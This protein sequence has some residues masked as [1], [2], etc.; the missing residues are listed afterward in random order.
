[1]MKKLLLFIF[2]ASISLSFIPTNDN[3]ISIKVYKKDRKLYLLKGSK[4]IAVYDIVLGFN[5]EGDKMQE[6]DGKTPEGTF[7][8]RAKYPHK[9]WNK[10]IWFDYPNKESIRKFNERT[11]NK[12]LDAKATIGGDVGIHGVPKGMD[13]AIDNKNDWTFGCISLRNKDVD[14]VYKYVKIGTLLYIHQ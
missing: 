14:T 2:I 4:N 8:I 10:F 6:G 13:H 11:K 12:E 5:P 9:S 1:M 7:K 3:Q